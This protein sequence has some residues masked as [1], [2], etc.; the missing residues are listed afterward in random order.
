MLP[1]A[2]AKLHKRYAITLGRY[3]SSIFWGALKYVYF[4]GEC[5]LHGGMTVML[6]MMMVVVKMVVLTM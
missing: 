3:V 2:D 1:S 5:N 6:I 4:V